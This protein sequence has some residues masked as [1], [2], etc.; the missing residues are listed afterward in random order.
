MWQMILRNARRETQGL[1][2]SERYLG[3]SSDFRAAEAAATVVKAFP[4]APAPREEEAEHITGVLNR[5]SR[6]TRCLSFTLILFIATF[7]D[8]LIRAHYKH[9]VTFARS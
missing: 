5:D 1:G 3:G 8:C 4:E 9:Q 6:G 7:G 2:A